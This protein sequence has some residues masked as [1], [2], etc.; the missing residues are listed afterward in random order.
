MNLL[1]RNGSITG[2]SSYLRNLW[3]EPVIHI[4]FF[5]DPNFISVNRSRRWT[6]P[7]TGK[8]YWSGKKL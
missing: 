4:E 1:P 8:L 5:L 6:P 2:F 7:P 3:Y